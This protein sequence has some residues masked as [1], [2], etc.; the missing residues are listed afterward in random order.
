MK[1]T[2]R[3]AVSVVAGVLL[4]A[5]VAVGM[6]PKQADVDACNKEAAAMKQGKSPS[7]APGSA[8]P[9]TGPAGGQGTIQNRPMEG[10]TGQQ[11]GTTKKESMSTTPP[12]SDV[13][14]GMAPVGE[15]DAAYR[16]TYLECMKKRG[17]TS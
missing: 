2:S 16:T 11:G 4:T 8:T 5:G 13:L 14:K 7:M 6:P 9:G 15:T 10:T 3:T 17:Y 12:A 1:G